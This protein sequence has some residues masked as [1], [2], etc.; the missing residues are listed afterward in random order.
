MK[1]PIQHFAVPLGYSVAKIQ[2]QEASA[3]NTPFMNPQLYIMTPSCTEEQT[4]APAESVNVFGLANLVALRDLLNK[5][6]AI[7]NKGASADALVEAINQNQ[8]TE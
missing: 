2:V 4:H 6:I 1:N 8:P 5:A 3:V 7:A